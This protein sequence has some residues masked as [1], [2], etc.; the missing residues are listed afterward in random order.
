MTPE[1]DGECDVD[2]NSAPLPVKESAPDQAGHESLDSLRETRP[3]NCTE[4]GA[5]LGHNRFCPGCQ[6]FVIDPDAGRLASSK[7]RLVAAWLDD[8]FSDGGILGLAGWSAVV[9]P[10]IARTIVGFV[11]AVYAIGTLYLWTRGTTPAKRMLGMYVITE[12]G[13]PAGFWRMACR[14]TVCK[15]VS[16][17]VLGLGVLS[18][19][20]D[21]ERQGWH[22]KMMK[23]WVIRETED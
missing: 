15:A 4:C 1:A 19:P 17:A 14:E 21:R 8:T 2:D 13:E 11:V 18:I 9:P 16:V 3:A 22:D 12:D 5:P 7:R 10:G 6:T 20:F 23:T